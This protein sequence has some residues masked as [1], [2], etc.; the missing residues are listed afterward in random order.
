MV[1]GGGDNAIDRGGGGGGGGFSET[2]VIL[3]HWQG[4]QQKIG[5]GRRQNGKRVNE[6]SS[7]REGV[8]YRG[9]GVTAQA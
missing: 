6:R 7:E 4:W 1:I 2:C 8:G 9:K 5:N 3:K